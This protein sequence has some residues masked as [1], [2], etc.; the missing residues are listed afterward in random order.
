MRNLAPVST[1]SQA[2][3]QLPHSAYRAPRFLHSPVWTSPVGAKWL[4]PVFSRRPPVG[5]PP[6]LSIRPGCRSN[7]LIITYYLRSSIYL[8]S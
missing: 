5:P 8:R 6:V 1:G 3:K 4:G 2:G 7:K